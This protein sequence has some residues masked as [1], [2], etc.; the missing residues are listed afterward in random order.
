MKSITSIV[1][2][3]AV[4]ASVGIISGC[5][6]DQSAPSRPR[7]G[8]NPLPD[9]EKARDNA[10]KR[11][12]EKPGRELPASGKEFPGQSRA[13]EKRA[14][15]VIT[16]DA[17]AA[18]ARHGHAVQDPAPRDGSDSVLPE[19]L[20]HQDFYPGPLPHLPADPGSVPMTG[21]T[22]LPGT[23]WSIEHSWGQVLVLRDYPH[24]D[25]PESQAT[26]VAATVKHNPPYYFN[27]QNRLPVP[28]NDGSYGGNWLTTL[29]EVP[30]YYINTAALP[31]MMF[32]DRPL[33]Q[34]TTQRLGGD[35][36]FFGYLPATGDI[37]PAPVPGVIKWDYPFLVVNHVSREPSTQSS[38]PIAPTPGI[39]PAPPGGPVPATPETRPQ[40]EPPATTPGLR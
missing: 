12:I 9:N 34:V 33:D 19:S 29:I 16:A 20:Y 36:N 5:E 15:T 17:R 24:R 7:T 1:L 6:G 32:I 23:Q 10:D 14:N 18:A 30:W 31:V 35:P 38:E 8:L 2:S 4:A 27:L 39:I 25:W 22:A 21:A 40:V 28:Q 11:A 37:V 3:V 13:P 26:Y